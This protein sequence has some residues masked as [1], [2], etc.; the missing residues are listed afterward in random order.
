MIG[1]EPM[2]ILFDLAIIQIRNEPTKKK[3]YLMNEYV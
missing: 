1:D 3:E 2:F